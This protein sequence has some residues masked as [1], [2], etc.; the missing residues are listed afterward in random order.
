MTRVLRLNT[1]ILGQ[2]SVSSALI[3][4]LLDGL[5]QGRELHVSE[6]D[7][8]TEPV[9]HVD[10]DWLQALMT[11][12]AERSADQ[13]RKVDYS[14]SLIAELQAA[15]ILVIGLPMYNFSVPSMLKAWNDHVARA[16]VTFKYTDS[17]AVGLLRDKKVYLVAAMGGIHE[18]G[19]SDFLR[20]YMKQFLGLLG[21]DDI[22]FITASG[23]NMGEQ[24]RADGIAGAQRE[25]AAAIQVDRQ[26]RIEQAATSRRATDVSTNE[27]KEKAA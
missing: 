23:L 9:P 17:G 1:S 26:Q 20:P 11:P 25:I 15:D 2:N 27:E 3:Q 10:S 16:G 6:R 14:D 7:F 21:L 12:E 5:G 8:G 13:Q 22:T 24:P 4:E 18:V 19:E